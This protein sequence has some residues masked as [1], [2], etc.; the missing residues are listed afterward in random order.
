LLQPLLSD[1]ALDDRAQPRVGRIARVL[2]KLGRLVEDVREEEQHAIADKVD[3][4]LEERQDE[5]RAW[6]RLAERC[7]LAQHHGHDI[8]ALEGLVELVVWLE[9]VNVEVG[10]AGVGL[11]DAIENGDGLGFVALWVGIVLF[12]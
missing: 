1:G 11:V 5:D 9:L 6:V 12:E 8:G 2:H 10:L 4:E 7:G 3:A